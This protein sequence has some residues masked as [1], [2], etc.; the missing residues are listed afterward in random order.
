M[1]KKGHYRKTI[2]NVMQILSL[3]K[4]YDKTGELLTVSKISKLT[5]LHKWT[6]SR[7]LDLHMQSFVE[8]TIP[9]GFEDVGLNIKFVRLR[10]P[11]ITKEQVLRLLKLR[12][13]TF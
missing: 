4:K 2:K 3:L 10:N 6:V 1:D 13:L 7:T 8:I 9:D 11:D 5:G 12:T